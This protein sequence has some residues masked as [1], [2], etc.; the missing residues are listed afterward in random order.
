MATSPSTSAW[1]IDPNTVH[2]KNF[3]N[4]IKLYQLFMAMNSPVS[5]CVYV[6]T[7]S[8]IY[9]GDGWYQNYLSLVCISSS[10]PN[11]PIG[12]TYSGKTG[13]KPNLYSP[14]TPYSG[15][16]AS[17]DGKTL[18]VI[19]NF[20]LLNKLFNLNRWKRVNMVTRNLNDFDMSI[21]R[22]RSVMIF[23]QDNNQ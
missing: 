11:L 21:K 13:T 8:T 20:E 4:D 15:Q 1:T 2:P 12:H 6:L 7:P 9:T 22:E 23:K 3:P 18:H 16:F 19:N 5:G 14:L 10:I 17:N